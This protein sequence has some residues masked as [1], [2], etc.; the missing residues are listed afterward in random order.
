M[1]SCMTSRATILRHC[2]VAVGAAALALGV[3]APAGATTTA[4]TVIDTYDDWDGSSYIYE[5]GN[6]NT[7]NYGQV[8][9]APAGTKKV[10][11]FTFYLA[12]STG[13]GT[14]TVRGEVYGWDGAAVHATTK[15]AESKKKQVELSQGDPTFY[16]VK[17]KVKKSKKITPGEQYVIFLT[18]DKDFEANPPMLLSK[19]ADVQTDV[20]PGGDLVFLNSG[21][22][23]SQWTSGTWNV[24]SGY[25]MAFTATLK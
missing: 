1:E 17:I 18:V 11:S 12:G 7:T 6:P 10:K 5:F 22:D 19:W 16:P 14:M 21:G 24:I 2:T 20:L 9:T 25:D 23:E 3:A 8:I 4:K 13:A 15:V